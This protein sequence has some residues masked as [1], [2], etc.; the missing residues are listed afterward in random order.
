M[1][2]FAWETCTPHLQLQYLVWLIGRPKKSVYLLTAFAPKTDSPF[3]P[4][5]LQLL[6]IHARRLI[7]RPPY[8]G[9]G[10]VA[11]LFHLSRWVIEFCWWPR[12][13]IHVQFGAHYVL[14][15]ITV[16]TVLSW[17]RA[18]WSPST[19]MCLALISVYMPQSNLTIVH[20]LYSFCFFPLRSFWSD[21]SRWSRH[22]T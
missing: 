19:T 4:M 13:P 1:F 21:L 3:L 18:R 15:R 16:T 2:S 9:L 5:G 14:L 11:T 17:L 22:C 20:W 10:H 8:T 6:H 7:E 12:N